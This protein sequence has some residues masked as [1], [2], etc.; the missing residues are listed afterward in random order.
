M[1]FQ[2]HLKNGIVAVH[3]IWTLATE[4]LDNQTFL[5]TKETLFISVTQMGNENLYI[6]D[7]Y[8]ESTYTFLIFELSIQAAISKI[9]IQIFRLLSSISLRH[10]NQLPFGSI[11][12]TP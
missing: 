5:N 1:N 11:K 12:K 7:H 9:L 8:F 3:G 2:F 10:Q 4:F 6:S